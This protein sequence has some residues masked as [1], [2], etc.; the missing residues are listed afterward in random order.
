MS[1]SLPKHE[2]TPKTVTQWR[3]E[4]IRA[5]FPILQ[6]T[7]RTGK[8]L[9]YLDSAATSQ[10]PRV[11]LDAERN[12]YEQHNAAA[13]RGSHQLAEEATEAYESARLTIAGFIGASDSEVVFTKSAT[14]SLNLIAYALLNATVLQS[15]GVVQDPRFVIAEGDNIVVTELEHHANLVPWQELALKTGAELRW[16][17]VASDGRLRIEELA[18]LVDQHTKV[19]SCAHVSNTLGHMLD[20]SAFASAAHA[21]NAIFVLDACQSIPHASINVPA[22]GADLAVFSAHKM[23][24]PTGLGIL[25]GR[26]E[27]L[28]ALPVVSTGGSM[29]KHVTM[30]SSTYQDSPARFEPGVPSMAQAIGTAA[31]VRYLEDLSMESVE[32]HVRHLS[33]YAVSALSQVP[34]VRVIASPDAPPIAAVSFILDGVHPHDVG[35]V[36][37]DDGIAVRVGHHCAWPLMRAL[38]VPATVRA[39]FSV[40]NSQSEVDALITSVIR[41]GDFF[42]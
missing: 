42:L 28:N 36:L 41:A 6:R 32:A 9:I 27:L 30:A 37:D 12:F 25:W 17:S 13:H 23:L 3:A 34:H 31:A 29:I 22:T 1:P 11:V 21:V 2:R 15:R 7:L 24:G 4:D 35:Q 39:S 26:G 40:Y 38:G 33:A 19:V 8:P 5:D 16:V 20:V 14:E 18:T 10:K